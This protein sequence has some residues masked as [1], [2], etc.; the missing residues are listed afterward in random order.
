MRKWNRS[1]KMGVAIITFLSIISISSGE[2]NPSSPQAPEL[3][4]TEVSAPVSVPVDIPRCSKVSDNHVLCRSANGRYRGR[5]TGKWPRK[6]FELLKEDGTVLWDRM[7]RYCR[8]HITDSG[9][10]IAV[11]GEYRTGLAF[12][13]VDGK[14]KTNFRERSLRSNTTFKWS[15]SAELFIVSTGS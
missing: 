1:Y 11:S 9:N 12:L 4:F 14:L 10:V 2:S 6:V 7:C 5:I 3:K 15:E 8:H 13:D